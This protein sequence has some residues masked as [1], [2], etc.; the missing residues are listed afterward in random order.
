MERREG[1]R[2]WRSPLGGVG[3]PRP[4]AL[5]KAREPFGERALRP[6]GAPSVKPAQSAQ[7]RLRDAI[8]RAP[9][10]A[11]F[12]ARPRD[13]GRCTRKARL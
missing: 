8:C 12:S 13:G 5:A 1:A 2:G 4:R 6:P 7:A 11:R 3:E 9:R 10:P